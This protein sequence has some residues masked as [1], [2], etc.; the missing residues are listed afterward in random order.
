MSPTDRSILHTIFHSFKIKPNHRENKLI[1]T[2]TQQRPSSL[3]IYHVNYKI[4]IKKKMKIY[5]ILR[6]QY[7]VILSLTSLLIISTLMSMIKLN[8][9]VV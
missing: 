1:F 8:Y 4:H 7:D 5:K 2:M 3:N 9:C 6:N